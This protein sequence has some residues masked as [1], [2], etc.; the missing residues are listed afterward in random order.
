MKKHVSLTDFDLWC[1]ISEAVEKVDLA[2]EDTAYDALLVV[3]A[4]VDL[5]WRR[6]CGRQQ[7]RSR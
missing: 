5:Y 7:V 6:A 1:I 3:K 4:I 2:Y